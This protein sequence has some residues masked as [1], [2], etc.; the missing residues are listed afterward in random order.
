[1]PPTPKRSLALLVSLTAALS[2]CALSPK[3]VPVG[4]VV[5]A[6]QVKQPPV[7]AL[8]QQTQPKPTGYFQRAMRQALEE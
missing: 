1:M 5:V 6:P 8:V 3:P 2:G 7:P 4:R